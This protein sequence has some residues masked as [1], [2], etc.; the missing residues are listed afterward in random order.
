MPLSATRVKALKD[1]GR[2]SDG[3][4]LHLFISKAG[5][6]SWVQR[7]TVDGRRR[8]IGLGGFPSVSLA[9]AREKAAENRAA[10]AG[11]RDP[12]RTSAGLRCRHSGMLHMPSMRRIDRA[13]ATGSTAQAGCRPWNDT[14]CPLWATHPSTVLTGPKCCESSRRYGRLGRR[15]PGGCVN[16]CGPYSDGRWRTASWRP[17]RRER[18]STAPCPLCRR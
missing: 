8:D 7:I 6:K 16:G 18:P 17:T 12:W 14:P 5:R 2:F 10:V 3:G 9:Q 11:G 1:P 13:G 15:R 4:G